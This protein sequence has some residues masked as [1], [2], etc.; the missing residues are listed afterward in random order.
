[1][2]AEE[3]YGII[4]RIVVNGFLTAEF[5]AQGSYFVMKNMTDREADTLGMFRDPGKPVEDVTCKLSF[6]TFAV[7]GQNFIEARSESIPGLMEFWRQAPV[8]LVSS[9]TDAV[10]G[11]NDR[12][13]EVLK[14]LEG[15][16]YT[17]RSRYLWRV[18]KEG[19][20]FS[21]P[22]VLSSGM[23]AVQENWS[24]VNRELDAEEEYHKQFNLSLMVA[25]SFNA[26][27]AK[28]IAQNYETSRTELEELRKEIAKWGY[29]RKRVEEEKRQAEWTA[30][31]RS[32]EDLVRELYRQMRGE[33]DKH[34]LFI[35]KWMQM[36]KDRASQA[37]SNAEERARLWREKS[38]MPETGMD[39]EESR[40]ATPEEVA[41]LSA[42]PSSFA[43]KYMSAYEGFQKDDR[44]LRKIG[45]RV[46]GD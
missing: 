43:S 5:R 23:N 32:R 21:I 17:D 37:K 19:G 34:D 27:G 18:Y 42:A 28:V 46:I 22:G 14:Y 25:S 41:A 12:Y 9:A 7:D 40:R 2:D 36:Q 1:M 10:R 6:C 15:F 8:S 29:D 35:E 11:I 4:E 33:K 16:C 45:A 38:Q 31:V 3:A 24:L 44:F 26:K 20:L 13:I 39:A 30:P